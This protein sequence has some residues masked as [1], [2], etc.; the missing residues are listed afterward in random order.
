MTIPV[1]AECPG[2]VNSGDRERFGALIA[3]TERLRTSF[4]VIVRVAPPQYR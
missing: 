1:I 2:Y 4:S 3:V